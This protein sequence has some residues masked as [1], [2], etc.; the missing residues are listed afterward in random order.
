MIQAKTRL[1]AKKIIYQEEYPDIKDARFSQKWV[2]GFMSRY[3]LVN[4]KRTTISQRLPDD[5]VKQ[6]S[7][8]YLMFF[9]VE[10]NINIHCL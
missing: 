3:N 2:D 5:Y 8:F 9:I 7:N 6:Q 4:R 10:E 1:L